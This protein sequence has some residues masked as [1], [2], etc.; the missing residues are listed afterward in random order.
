LYFFQDGNTLDEIDRLQNGVILILNNKVKVEHPDQIFISVRQNGKLDGDEI[1]I[2]SMMTDFKGKISNGKIK[3]R[4]YRTK[5]NKTP[6]WL[7][8]I[9]K[10]CK[11]EFVE[12]ETKKILNREE[13]IAEAKIKESD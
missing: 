5:K 3:L 6:S 9:I 1:Y 2:K 4:Y 13:A 12:N 10:N 7:E 8:R 11:F